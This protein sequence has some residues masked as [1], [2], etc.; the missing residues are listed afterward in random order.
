MTFKRLDVLAHMLF[1]LMLAGVEIVSPLSFSRLLW[2][3][4]SI[5]SFVESVVSD[6]CMSC[7]FAFVGFG[8]V[9]YAAVGAWLL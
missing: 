1:R 9:R 7:C 8:K 2:V 4:S 6:G 3:F 5:V